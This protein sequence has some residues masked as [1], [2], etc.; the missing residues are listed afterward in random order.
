[1]LNSY[2]KFSING[3]YLATIGIDYDN[4][5]VF[6]GS[7]FC[8]TA[9]E[10]HY[11]LCDRVYGRKVLRPYSVKDPQDVKF[12]FPG[13]IEGIRKHS[14]CHVHAGTVATSTL[15]VKGFS[16]RPFGARPSF[17]LPSMYD[18]HVREM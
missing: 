17:A 5:D 13:D 8:G 9:F 4:F 10:S 18:N 15:C 11:E 7:E 16:R 12:S 2:T 1:M 14:E 3:S 6:L